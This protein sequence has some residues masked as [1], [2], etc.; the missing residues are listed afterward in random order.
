MKLIWKIIKV[1]F[2]LSITL[3]I[4]FSISIFV[5]RDELVGLFTQ[6]V[7]RVLATDVHIDEIDVSFWSKFP[8]ASIDLNNVII[9]EA[10]PNSKDT[11]LKAQNIYL[12]FDIFSL[13]EKNYAIKKCYV[14]NAKGHFKIDKYG[15]NN[16]SIFK[17]DTVGS[18]ESTALQFQ[19]NEVVFKNINLKYD[20]KQSKQLYHVQVHKL[21]NSFEMNNELI[22]TKVQGGFK[23]NNIFIENTSYVRNKNIQLN[24]AINHNS[25]SQKTVLQPSDLVIEKARFNLHGIIQ[26]EATATDLNISFKGHKTNIQ[27]LLSLLPYDVYKKFSDYDSRG[28]VYFN[29]KV[30]GKVSA[31]KS[32]NIQVNFGFED[33]SF[34]HKETTQQ[35]TEAN[36]VGTYS[37]G[38]KNGTTTSFVSLKNINGKLNNIPFNGNFLMKNFD[39]PYL[40]A[41]L[42]GNFDVNALLSLSGIQNIKQATGTIFTNF[43]L[44]GFLADLT[45][46]KRIQNTQLSGAI[47]VENVNLDLVTLNYP[48]NDLSGEILINKNNI[49]VS[50][51]IANIGSSKLKIQGYFYHFITY[52][53][54]DN[55]ILDIDGKITATHLQV[56]ELLNLVKKTDTIN[57]AEEPETHFDLPS[58]WAL[59]LDCK[60]DTIQY[61]QFKEDNLLRD[62]K[63]ELTLKNQIASFQNLQ[64]IIAKGRLGLTGKVNT[65]ATD[66]L[67]LIGKLSL[68]NIEIDRVFLL[69]NNFDQ[70]FFTNKNI[71]GEL[72]GVIDTKMFLKK[73]LS[74]N[75]KAFT[76][77]IDMTID[78]G[79][80]IDF[81]P[82]IEMGE[83][84]KKKKLSRYLKNDDLSTIAFSQLKNHIQIQH[85]TIFIPYMNII[86]S[87]N[88]FTISGK[89]TFDSYIDY[90]VEVPI[91]NYNRKERNEQLGIYQEKNSKKFKLFLHVY[92]PMDS[93]EIELHKKDI[94]KSA[95]NTFVQG[96]TESVKKDKDTIQAVQIEEGELLD[97][98]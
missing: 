26:Q 77:S 10:Y 89:H 48:L 47:K 68:D 19:L 39:K 12:A 65:Q 36:L 59:R 15:K 34:F 95:V 94:L 40:E 75:T 71:K 44:K 55:E 17:E 5:F 56:D 20:N 14:E 22:S 91:V 58:D 4:T 33:A 92:G 7:S 76:A 63:G 37:N 93:Y 13:I 6:K 49:A 27:S 50:N 88:D 21:T 72:H 9:I 98:E 60:I 29:G 86:S 82:M 2:L 52:L 67:S 18:K 41:D 62:I 3:L 43:N 96:V 85:D 24:I 38:A 30:K 32:P 31:T 64:L 73:D 84:M 97:E 54:V 90:D 70:D 42:I 51:V 61:D 25:E 87:A 79:K 16:Y 66:S 81:Q 23:I 45:D 69:M 57:I 46:K 78:N 8:D 53:L 83:Y 11:L 28:I 35:I 1:F 74:F 80:F